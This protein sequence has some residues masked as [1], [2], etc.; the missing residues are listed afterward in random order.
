MNFIVAPQAEE[1][2]DRFCGLYTTQCCL[3]SEDPRWCGELI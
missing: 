3:C 1:N 2:Q